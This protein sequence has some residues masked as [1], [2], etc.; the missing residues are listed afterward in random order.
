MRDAHD[1]AGVELFRS[2]FNALS[3]ALR[4]QS[5][6]HASVIDGVGS[7]G[8]CFRLSMSSLVSSFLAPS[9]RMTAL[10][11][12][13]QEALSADKDKTVHPSALQFYHNEGQNR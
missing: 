6:Q 4:Q 2:M 13:V 8:P 11:M 9:I 1:E 12:P 3:Q 5:L 7:L 10:L